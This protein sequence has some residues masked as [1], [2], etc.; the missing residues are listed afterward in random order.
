MACSGYRQKPRANERARCH[1]GP[2]VTVAQGLLWL[3]SITEG[4][5][6]QSGPVLQI[7]LITGTRAM[8]GAG[9]TY[10][11]LKELQLF[12]EASNRVDARRHSR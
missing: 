10:C 6:T 11:F 3:I 1:V 5:T 8:L 12:S 9:I 7:G 2:P 4:E